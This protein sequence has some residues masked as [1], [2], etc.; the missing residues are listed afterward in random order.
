MK[1][2]RI[3][4]LIVS[5]A[6]I[7]A[8]CKKPVDYPVIPAL[9]FK[10]MFTTK[11]LNGYDHGVFVITNFTDGDG[12]IGYYKPEENKNDPIFDDTL[13][14][15]YNNYQVKIFH[16]EN[17]IWSPYYVILDLD[18]DGSVDDTVDISSRIPY[19]TPESSNKNLKGEIE[20]ELPLDIHLNSD[21]FRFDI[22]IYDRG[23]H[24]SN[25]ITTP[26]VV[27]TTQ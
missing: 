20:R 22:F 2:F 26:E 3:I 15:Y 19:L 14:P 5:T 4:I 27:V 25:A 24:Q 18:N 10:E 12:D 16:K 7:F 21:T 13:S 23:L 11:D 8:A 9:E 1:L 17:G 6:A